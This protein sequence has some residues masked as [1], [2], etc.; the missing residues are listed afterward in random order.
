MA[1]KKPRRGSRDRPTDVTF[2]NGINGIVG[3][4]V[5]VGSD[6]SISVDQGEMDIEYEGGVFHPVQKDAPSIKKK[7][8]R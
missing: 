1:R 6:G 7:R 3:M 8:R 4:T 5:T 2:S